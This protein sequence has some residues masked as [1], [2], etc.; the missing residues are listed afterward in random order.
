MFMKRALL[1]VLLTLAL[2][3]SA[4]GSSSVSF[5]NSD[6][7]LSGT[8]A[9]LSLSD[10]TLISVN[11]LN[12]MGLI[13]GDLGTVVFSTGA[14]TSGS[15]AGNA[16]FAAGGSFVITGNGS[17][18][19]PNT[20]L[21]NGTFTGPVTWTLITSNGTNSYELSGALSGTWYNGTTVYGATTQLTVDLGTSVFSGS[22][23][24]AS[25][26]TNISVVPEP[27]SLALFGTGLLGIVGML[28]RKLKT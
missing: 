26:E 24:I 10:S 27:G 18:G 11:G 28:R 23:T 7:T 12:G 1:F 6:G 9:G 20:V 19:I 13:T 3:V 5:T 21:F 16:T 17:N 14:L 4:F 25:G 2:S 22:A 8:T 15:L